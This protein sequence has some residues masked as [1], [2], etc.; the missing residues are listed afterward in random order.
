[1]AQARRG[2]DIATMR[3]FT[4]TWTD[5]QIAL[6]AEWL[7]TCDQAAVLSSFAGFHEDDVHRDLALLGRS[8]LLV[9]ADRGDVV[10]DS[11]VEECMRLAPQLQHVRVPGAGHMIPWDNLSGFLAA[12]RPFL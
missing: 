12:V 11:D 9:S 1:M 6:R 5:E 2:A 3:P 10:L 4:P 7:H 8:A